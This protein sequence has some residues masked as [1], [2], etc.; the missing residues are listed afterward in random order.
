MS[1]SAILLSYLKIFIKFH[2][3]IFSLL[4]SVFKNI[5]LAL[6]L[7]EFHVKLIIDSI[8]ILQKIIANIIFKQIKYLS[9]NIYYTKKYCKY[10]I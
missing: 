9:I 7:L 6:S 8:F 2:Y 3:E 1:I 4:K 10:N 5:R